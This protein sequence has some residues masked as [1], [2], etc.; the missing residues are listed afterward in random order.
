MT[1][2]DIRIRFEQYRVHVRMQRDAASSGLRQPAPDR[3]RRSRRLCRH[4][5]RRIERRIQYGLN[6]A[7][8][9]LTNKPTTPM[10][11]QR[12]LACIGCA[13]LYHQ[14]MRTHGKALTRH[15]EC[16]V[17][18]KAVTHHV[19]SFRPAFARIT[20][21]RLVEQNRPTANPLPPTQ[22]ER[23][24]PTPRPK[25][26]LEPRCT[27]TRRPVIS[28]RSPS[29][30]LRTSTLAVP[31]TSWTCAACGVGTNGT[32]RNRSGWAS[33][34]L[35]AMHSSGAHCRQT[36]AH[37]WPRTIHDPSR[38]AA[39][40]AHRDGSHAPQAELGASQS[41]SRSAQR[42]RSQGAR[43][44]DPELAERTQHD[45]AVAARAP[46]MLAAGVASMASSTVNQPP[47]AASC[48]C[49]A[50]STAGSI[51]QPVGLFGLTT[52]STS[53]AASAASISSVPIALT[54]QPAARRA[55]AMQ[56]RLAPRR[57][58]CLR[59]RLRANA[60]IAG[61]PPASPPPGNTAVLPSGPWS[62]CRAVVVF[63]GN[64]RLP[65]GTE[66]TQTAD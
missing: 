4:R 34:A 44:P 6:G 12:A 59:H 27:P 39:R 16:A 13:A 36:G 42:G 18:L 47:R 1:C 62:A 2:T 14:H 25:R 52:M 15:Q 63:R 7:T 26:T 40:S 22:T 35:P 17:R 50:N 20:N 58:A 10:Y 38:R 31:A 29:S 30:K 9:T 65:A 66:G 21:Q 43:Q 8:L 56:R 45:E 64:A 51:K 60:A 19:I 54:A 53:R 55:F 24:M 57:R 46:A 5:P 23:L 49:H 33:H 41:L 48:S 61:L 28:K 3:S 11:N 37:A 32:K